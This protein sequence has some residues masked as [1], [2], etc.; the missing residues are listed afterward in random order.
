MSRCVSV[1]DGSGG[2]LLSVRRAF[3]RAGAKVQFVNDGDG[4]RKAERI[5]VPGVGA[6]GRGMD[7]LRGLALV[8]PL[9]E[10]IAGGGSVLGI[11]L[12][13]QFLFEVGE[14]F[15][16][17][18]GLGVLRGRVRRLPDRDTADRPLRIP[19]IGWNALLRPRDET[20]WRGTILERVAPG[21]AVYFVHS[22]AAEP[23]DPRNILAECEYGGHRVVAAV[24]HGR[25]Y[26]VQF[27]PEKSGETGL[28]IIKTF[29][30]L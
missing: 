17:H 27:H 5:V 3:E 4:I 30:E 18:S 21:Y 2:N 12:G 10:F 24:Q 28:T 22:F 20:Q 26:G 13:L 15:G 9:R 14:E 29:L 11:C 16:E 8:E 25:L 6:F 23:V 7:A 19:H 1:I